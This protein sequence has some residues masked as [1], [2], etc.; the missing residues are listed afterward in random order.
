MISRRSLFSA[1]LLALP[2]LGHAQPT[3]DYPTKPVTIVVPFTPGQAGD[4]LARFLSEPLGKKLSSSVVVE[5][6]TGAGGIIGTQY[7]M[8]APADGYTLLLGSSGPMSIVPAINPKAGYDPRTDF[9]PIVFAGGVPQVVVVATSSKIQSIAELV[10]AARSAPGTL[11]YGSGGTGST[12]HLAMELIKQKAG[13]DIQHVPYKGTAP[14][15]TDLIGGSITLLLDSLPGAIAMAKAG[16]V[17]MLAVTTAK[18]ASA[19][20]QV[21]TLAESGVPGIDV[22]AWL[23]IVGPSNMDPAIRDQL[24]AEANELLRD[25]ALKARLAAVGIEPMGGSPDQF[26][27][28]IASEFAKW[29]DV[30]KAGGL[31][32]ME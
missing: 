19:L 22:T 21:P 26:K 23:G 10:D 11:T 6:R 28:F 17:R 30:I 29:S 16:Q 8:R 13:L 32:M 3:H 2:V 5:N 9:T 15:Y 31:K 25:D 12:Q 24:N 1:A 14:A 27:Q 4:V 18:R 7:V 20:P